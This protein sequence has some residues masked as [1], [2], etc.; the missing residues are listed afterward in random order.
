MAMEHTALPAAPSDMNAKYEA[1]I[2]SKL[3]ALMRS[4]GYSQLHF[5]QM[6]KDRGLDIGQGNLSSMLKGRKRI[7]LSLIVHICDIFQISL[8]ELV[9]E[10]FGGA[11]QVGGDHPV[12]RVYSEDLLQ[13]IPDLGSKFVVDPADPHFFGYLQTYYIYLFP[14]QSDDPRIR[15]GKLHLRAKDDVCEAVLEIGTN[16]IRDGKPFVKVYRG[17]CIISTTM[18]SVFVLLTDRSGGELSIINF[19]YFTLLQSPLDC[20]IACT[21]LSSAG[22]EH[23]PMVQRIFLSRTEIAEEHLPLLQ[24]HLRLNHGTIQ[25]REDQLVLLRNA[26]ASFHSVID[27]L[28]LTNQPDSFYCFDE[29]DVLSTAKRHLTKPEIYTFLTLLRSSSQGERVHKAS[30]RADTLAHKFLRSLGYYHDFEN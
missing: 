29:D 8:A 15:C 13:L 9:D 18:R 25:L 20:R 7:P 10:N 1:A 27:E 2:R 4:N 21:L 17:R 16:K 5:C 22:D 3:D 14:S 24:P 6:L 28:T 30:R 11:R 12:G 26:H 23:P 19:R